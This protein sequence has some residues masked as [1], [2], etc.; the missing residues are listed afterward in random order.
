[1]NG[2]VGT[3]AVACAVIVVAQVILPAT[4]DLLMSA[5]LIGL[6]GFIGSKLAKK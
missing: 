5:A 6:G 2:K 4:I 3:A 1:M